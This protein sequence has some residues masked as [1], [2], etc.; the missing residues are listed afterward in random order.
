MSERKKP[1]N[2]RDLSGHYRVK[3][4]DVEDLKTDPEGADFIEDDVRLG[5]A[6]ADIGP[7]AGQHGA[8]IEELV[9]K[10]RQKKARATKDKRSG[11]S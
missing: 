9:E 3:Q 4:V 8:R 11:P 1:H 5:G 10:D 7:N 2:G 6:V